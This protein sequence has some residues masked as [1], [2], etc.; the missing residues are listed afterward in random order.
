MKKR[1]PAYTLIIG[2]DI[3]AE[4]NNKLS[5]MGITHLPIKL[6]KLEDKDYA[7]HTIAAYGSFENIPEATSIKITIT[8]SDNEVLTSGNVPIP[9]GQQDILVVAGKFENIRFT[10]SGICK[11]TISID[12][13]DFSANFHVKIK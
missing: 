4:V 8:D 13:L 9:S 2:E 6:E 5:I 11:L 3:R 7:T 10:K 1:Q 12:D